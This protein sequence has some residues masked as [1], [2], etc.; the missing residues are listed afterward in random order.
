[1]TKPSEPSESKDERRVPP[2]GSAFRAAQLDLTNRIEVARKAG[3]EQ[4]ANNERET[5]ARKAK[6]ER[7]IVYR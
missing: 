5:A 6:R 4:R 1:M 2:D 3:R 7:G